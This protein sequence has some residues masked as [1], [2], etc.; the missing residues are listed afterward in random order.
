MNNNNKN[1]DY[2]HWIRSRYLADLW[3]IVQQLFG[4]KAVLVFDEIIPQAA[5]RE[6]L[7]D[8]AEVP[9][10][11]R[12]KDVRCESKRRPRLGAHVRKHRFICVVDMAANALGRK[13]VGNI[14]V[15]YKI[16]SGGDIK[17]RDRCGTKNQH[18]KVYCVTGNISL[19]KKCS[20]EK[21][22]L[23]NTNMFYGNIMLF[24]YTSAAQC[25]SYFIFICT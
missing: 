24:Y 17:S 19:F 22:L 10:P 15:H 21:S 12:K 9:S 16:F 6:I 1:T 4:I 25:W 18:G 13:C 7:H 23:I 2:L 5:K 3:C 11:C 8:Q 20:Q 14:I